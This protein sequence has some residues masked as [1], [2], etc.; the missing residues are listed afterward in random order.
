MTLRTFVRSL[1]AGAAVGA[2]TGGAM[3]DGSWPDL[4][5]GVKSGIA[6]RVGDTAKNADRSAEADIL[7]RHIP[8][9]SARWGTRAAIEG[10]ATNCAA[11]AV[12]ADSI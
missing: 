3:A 11:A 9:P 1:A 2:S 6:A 12:S 7:T 8:N 10:A 5:V 4:P